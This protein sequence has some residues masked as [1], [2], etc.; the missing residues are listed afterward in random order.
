MGNAEL[1]AVFAEM[2]ELMDLKG[3]EDRYRV[4][5]FRRISR[6]LE[7][8]PRSVRQMMEDGTLVR[9]PGIGRGG[10]ERIKE[11]L[12]TGTCA[13]HQ[14]LLR[15]LPSGLR[16]LAEIKGLGKKTIRLAYTHLRVGSLAELEWAARAGKLAA[17]PGLPPGIDERVLVA[18]EEHR[19]RAG[20]QTLA[21]AIELGESFAK[22]LETAYGV[23][24]AILAGSS[25][26]RKPTVGDLDVLVAADDAGPVLDRFISRSDIIKV[27]RKGDNRGSVLLESGRQVDVVVR[28]A[29]SFGA[30]LHYFTGSQQHNIYLRARGN[31]LGLKIS[32]KGVF[33]RSDESLVTT[34]PVESQIF[35]AVGLPFIPPELRENAGEIEAA[36]KGAL[37]LLVEETDLRGELVFGHDESMLHQLRKMGRA[38]VICVRGSNE[39]APDIGAIEGTRVLSGLDV[40]ID[41]QGGFGVSAKQLERAEVVRARLG[42]VPDES[43]RQAA[44]RLIRAMET[45]LVD[46]VAFDASPVLTTKRAPT[47][48]D[49]E[50]VLEAARR[51]GIAMELHANRDSMSVDSVTAR[52]AKAMGVLVLPTLGARTAEDVSSRRFDIFVAR[53]G[54][55]SAPDVLTTWPLERL[56]LLRSQRLSSVGRAELVQA[57]KPVEPDELERQRAQRAS[58][59][60]E[61]ALRPLPESLADRL[62]VY[63]AEGN[64]EELERV[65]LEQSE[66]PVQA[67]F[68]MLLGQ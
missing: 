37:P 7:H 21:E 42:F 57:P 2:A 39:L 43:S 67:A 34:A 48:V 53:R 25:R 24:R 61:L 30:A 31:R 14:R 55:L 26:R 41:G 64:D 6:V 65:L 52:Q 9:T 23:E 49:I 56:L 62:R 59:A 11:I 3:G 47:S 33:H 63:L 10:V 19:H 51:H 60:R 66:N 18:L 8:L 38:W 58:L 22:E 17:V 54:W 4:R 44:F 27:L 35:A 36:A 28:P 5:A 12:R 68:A 16:E 45:G 46:L 1:A 29:A 13:E 15:A 32:D 40:E 20:R 50:L